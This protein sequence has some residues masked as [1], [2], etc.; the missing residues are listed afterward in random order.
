VLSSIC[1]AYLPAVEG[2]THLRIHAL[3]PDLAQDTEPV[4]S[5]QHDVEHDRVVCLSENLSERRATVMHEINHKILLC[6]TIAEKASKFFFVFDDQHLHPQS[7][8]ESVTRR[9]AG[10]DYNKT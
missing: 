5:W 8:G 1:S 4:A 6:E 10:H 7:L 2:K 9:E 3:S